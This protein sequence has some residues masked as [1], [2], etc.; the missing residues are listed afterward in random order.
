MLCVFLYLVTAVVAGLMIPIIHSLHMRMKNKL[1]FLRSEL[2]TAM[3]G[4]K[5]SDYWRIVS[6][7][8]KHGMN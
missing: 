1:R 5:V 7:Y 6:H 4:E 8:W 2:N 3:L